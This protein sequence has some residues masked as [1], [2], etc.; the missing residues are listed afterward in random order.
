[1][2]VLVLFMLIYSLQFWGGVRV[3]HYSKGAKIFI[4]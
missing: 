2:V 1:M 3:L 4:A